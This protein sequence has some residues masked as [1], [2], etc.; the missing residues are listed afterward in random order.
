MYVYIYLYIYIYKCV[1]VNHANGNTTPPL[2]TNQLQSTIM[3]ESSSGIPSS[4]WLFLGCTL[5]H[6]LA[7]T[8]THTHTRRSKFICSRLFCCLT[9]EFLLKIDSGCPKDAGEGFLFFPFLSRRREMFSCRRQDVFFSEE[10]MFLFWYIN[11]LSSIQKK[12]CF[13]F[14]EKRIFAI[15]FMYIYICVY[16]YIY[17]YIHIY[18][19]VYIHIYI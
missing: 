17:T 13:F 16:I 15:Y 7:H 6:T 2:T 19:Y 8:H 1:Y 3:Y 14:W 10:K 5:S 12:T 4:F 18:I 9:V 11:I